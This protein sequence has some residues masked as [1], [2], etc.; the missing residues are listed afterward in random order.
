[1]KPLAKSIQMEAILFVREFFGFFFTF[2]FPPIMLLIFGS[3]YGN[4]PS[5][6]FGGLGSMDVTVPSYVAMVIGVTGLMC[7]P[8]TLAEYKEKM[9]YK[10]F[11]ATPAGKGVVIGAQIIVNFV[12]AVFG[13]VLLVVL[14]KAVYNIQIE[15]NAIAIAGAVLLSIAA[16]FSLGFFVTAISRDTK[17]TNLICYLMYF[18]MLFVSG[19]S[20]PSEMLPETMRNVSKVLPLTHVVDLMKGVFAG[21]PIQDYWGAVLVLAAL[22]IVLGGLGVL[23]YKRKRWA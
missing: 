7:F 17:I 5:A 15:G 19:A 23:V 14:G 20:L 10:R 9:V 11:D 16:I 2:C 22:T 13:I 18:V 3:I 1:M 12:M 21:K 4:E 6:M 8:L